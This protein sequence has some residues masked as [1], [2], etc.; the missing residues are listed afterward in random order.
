MENTKNCLVEIGTEEL[1]FSAQKIILNDAKKICEEL[2]TEKKI[3]FESVKIF[4]TPLRIIIFIKNISDFQKKAEKEII[5]PLKKIAFDDG[6]NPT[7]ALIGFLEKNSAKI[8]D[9]LEKNTEKGVYLCLKSDD[10]PQQTADILPMILQEFL[11]KLPFHKMMV[12]KNENFR[13]IRPIRWILAFLGDEILIFEIASI[14]AQNFTFKFGGF[15]TQKIAVLSQENYFQIMKGEKIEIDFDERKRDI[16]TQIQNLIRGFGKLIS[17][18]EELLDEVA[19][20]VEKPFAILCDFDEKFLELPTEVIYT[21]LKNH[22]KCFALLGENGK[23]LNKF[24]AIANG[25]FSDFSVVKYGYEKVAIARLND[26]TFF[27]QNDKNLDFAD[28]KGKL[29][30]LVFQ[31]KLGSMREKIERMQKIFLMLK[32]KI[33]AA[34]RN[35]DGETIEKILDLCKNDLLTEMVYEFPELQGTMGKYYAANAGYDEEISRGIEEHYLPRFAGDGFPTSLEASIASICDKMDSIASTFI[36]GKKP[37]GSK[38]PFGLRRQLNGIFGILKNEKLPL[39]LFLIFDEIMSLFQSKFDKNIISEAQNELKKFVNIRLEN[40]LV[41][42]KNSSFRID[43][44]RAVIFNFDECNPYLSFIN[45]SKINDFLKVEA[46]KNLVELFKRAN[47]ILKQATEKKLEFQNW[48]IKSEIF[49]ASEKSLYEIL[50]DEN[51]FDF[52]KFNEQ[53][54]IEKISKLKNNL[55]NFFDNTM[56]MVDDENLRK[57]RLKMLSLLVE[58]L[59]VTADFSELS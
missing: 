57:N 16:K 24:M 29:E 21:V 28:L 55:D 2:L 41:E 53:I 47:N 26:A 50:L 59:K 23:L 34:N 52:F 43:V 22:Q 38:D 3:G 40:W 6:N 14:K 37:T 39:N 45:C 1:P 49:T 33:Q 54:F 35:F 48:T 18:G 56:V 58:R 12:W 25:E 10:K 31:E 42:E 36:S 46:F 32:P 17:E 44:A 51:N 9:L 27:Y 11:T 7:K 20:L 13:F 30:D 8:S 4:S 19:S 15:K 5:G